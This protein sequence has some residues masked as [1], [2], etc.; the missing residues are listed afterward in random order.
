VI[1]YLDGDPKSPVDEGDPVCLTGAV[2]AIG[3][4]KS[5]RALGRRW[6][7]VMSLDKRYQVKIPADSVTLLRMSW[8]KGGRCGFSDAQ[9]N[10]Q[11]GKRM[12]FLEI[13]TTV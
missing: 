11:F 5:V 4:I 1:T 13:D 3:R 6:E 2:E 12:R 10:T 8:N 9:G 7:V